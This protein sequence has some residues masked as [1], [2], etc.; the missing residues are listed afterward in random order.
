MKPAGALLLGLLLCGCPKQEAP[1]FDADDPL[2]KKLK[3]EQE[4]L[5]QAGPPSGRTPQPDPLAA[6]IAAP[7]KPESLGIP[8]GV[9]A[10]L[11]PVALTLVEVQQSQQVGTDRVWVTTS[12]RFLKVALEATSSE[13]VVLDFSGAS[14][15]REGRT[16]GLAR[17]AQRA[18]KGS[19][20]S[21]TL[22]AGKP[23][24][25]VLFFEAPPE[26]IRKGL[27]IILASGES[28]VELVLQ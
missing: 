9:A 12:D 5:A 24:P 1:G 7:S 4:R 26:M 21:L 2:L 17:D 18:G 25:V 14:L 22:R 10:D 16:A 19:P 27:K 8:Q 15:E 13:D 11:G 3:A 6:V 20:L 28:R 23:Q